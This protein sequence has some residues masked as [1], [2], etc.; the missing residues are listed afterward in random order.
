MAL[1]NPL[2]KKLKAASRRHAPD[3]KLDKSLNNL[4]S[5]LRIVCFGALNG[6]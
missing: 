3:K 5:T 4:S 2:T 6:I 1:A